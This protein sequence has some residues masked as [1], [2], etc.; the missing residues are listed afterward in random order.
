MKLK[1]LFSLVALVLIGSLAL[2]ETGSAANQQA[3]S[4]RGEIVAV[5]ENGIVVKGEGAYPLVKVMVDSST[6]TKMKP[7]AEVQGRYKNDMGIN[8]GLERQKVITGTFIVDGANGRPLSFKKLLVGKQ[9]VA[10]YDGNVTRSYP[11]Q[12]NGEVVVLVTKPEK[13]GKYVVADTVEM[14][15]DRKYVSVTNSTQ[16]LIV[17]IPGKACSAFRE[18]KSGTK[19][20]VWSDIMTMSIPAQTVATKVKILD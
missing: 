11:P 15:S 3:L 20:L 10:Y 17:R 5:E 16:D 4:T 7:S 6:K 18:I 14:S 12:A 2:G 8:L 1:K 19:L 9:V 13:I